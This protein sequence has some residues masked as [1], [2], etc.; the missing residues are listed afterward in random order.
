MVSRLGRTGRTSA[1]AAVLGIALT[2]SGCAAGQG[3]TAEDDPAP[4][5]SAPTTPAAERHDIPAVGVVPLATDMPEPLRLTRSSEHYGE[6]QGVKGTMKCPK[7]EKRCEGVMGG[8][9]TEYGEDADDKNAQRAKFSVWEY[10]SSVSARVAFDHWG[11]YLGS[12]AKGYMPL[13][14]GEFGEGAT[15][16]SDAAAGQMGERAMVVRQ[17]KYVGVVVTYTKADIADDGSPG[18]TALYGLTKML[19]ERMRRADLNQVPTA[20]A[21][22]LDLTSP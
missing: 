8:G 20:S 14:Q 21:H 2:V 16:V 17:G 5:S 18:P 9:N 15:A 3:S 1:V 13:A 19:V 12:L 7:S 6:L 11:K 4:R 22:H 10:P